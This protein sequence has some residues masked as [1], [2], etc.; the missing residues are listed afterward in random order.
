[1]KVDPIPAGFHS[2]TP[3]LTVEGADKLIRFM[4]AAFDA[5][6]IECTKRPD[7]KIANA[8]LK[9]GD[10]MI[11]AGDASGKWAP[12]P[13]GLYFYVPDVDEVYRRALAAGAT[14]LMEPADQF[15][16]DRNAGVRD[17]CGNFWWI[18][19]HIEDVSPDE[20]ERR[21]AERVKERAS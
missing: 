21:A 17:M 2:L 5:K 6:E 20:M 7:G 14:S 18:A 13:A 15:Y 9:I 16:G 11:M 1:M 3:Y 12:M 10:S 4:V 19:T 8:V